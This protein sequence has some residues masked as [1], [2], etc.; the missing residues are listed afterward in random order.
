MSAPPNSGAGVSPGA[1][2]LDRLNHSQVL[3]I[4]VPIILANVTTPLI[5]LIDTAVLGQLG[6]PHYIGGVALGAMIFNF[7]YWGFG[8]LRM[9]TTGLTAQAEGSGDRKETGA[10]LMRALLIAVGAGSLLILLQQPILAAFMQLIGGSEAVETSAADYFDIRIWASPAGLAN[11]AFLG[12]FIGIGRARTAL[13]LQLLLNGTNAV[14]DAWFVLGL[15][16]DVKGVAYGSLISEVMA[17][18]AGLWLALSLLK[19]RGTSFSLAR[20]LDRAALRRT[21]SVNRDIMI[22]TVCVLFAFT[23]FTAKSAEAGDVVLAA[24]SVLMTLTYVAAY[25]LDGFAFSAET[26]AGQAIGAQRIN[27]F[28]DAV[29]LSTAWAIAFSIAASLIFWFAGDSIIN[30]LTVNEDVRATAREYLVWATLVP[31]A[32]VMAYQLDG[33]FIGA[34]RTADMRNMMLISLTCYLALWAILTPL[35]GNHGLW[36]SIIIFVGLRALTLGMRYPALVR[37]SFSAAR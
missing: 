29:R 15:G 16:L 4:A 14:L 11:F 23:W 32:G 13:L 12:W 28:R 6:D 17:A 31:I 35:Y 10:T 25:F 3:A 5:G 1:I 2:D 19:Q 22:R 26:L 33:I 9:G 7:L 8:F 37:T 18:A 21:I 27:R 34:T 36:A 24:N 20:V 30:L